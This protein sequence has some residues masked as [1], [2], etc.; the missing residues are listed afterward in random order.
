MPFHITRSR[1]ISGFYFSYRNTTGEIEARDTEVRKNLTAEQRRQQMPDR[2]DGNT[3]FARDADLQRSETDDRMERGSSEVDADGDPLYARNRNE[4]NVEA[5]DFVALTKLQ[6]R[7][8]TE[9]GLNLKEARS[10]KNYIQ[11]TFG[12]LN[13]KLNTGTIAEA[14]M[15]VV[16]RISSALKKFPTFEGRTYRNLKFETE[17]Q[18]DAFLSEYA[19]G[20]TITLKAFTSTSK[21]PN[22]SS[23]MLPH[24]RAT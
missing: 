14:D 11:G 13:T 12:I 20:N 17:E 16:E 3:V 8:V 15:G 24:T 22:T 9:F 7:S 6:N 5:V 19:E 10:L 4:A 1:R 23:G 2:G 18:Y 21:R